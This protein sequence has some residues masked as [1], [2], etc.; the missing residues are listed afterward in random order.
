MMELGSVTGCQIQRKLAK[1]EA[2]FQFC[3]F[4]SPGNSDEPSHIRI[5][6]CHQGLHENPNRTKRETKTQLPILHSDTIGLIKRD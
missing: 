2:E 1:E 5:S 6:A 3:Y 4:R